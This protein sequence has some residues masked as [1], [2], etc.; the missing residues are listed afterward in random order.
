[1][2]LDTTHNAFH[3]SYIA[4]N[5]FRKA[6]AAAAGGSYPPHDPSLRDANGKPLR[7]DMWYFDND[8]TSREKNPGLAIFLSHSDCD[9]FLTPSECQIIA[10][11]IEALLP[12]IDEQDIYTSD[13]KISRG[14]TS[15][16]ARK[17]I[18]GCRL[19]ARKQE[20]LYFM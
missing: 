12:I 4:F 20:N 18:N 8:I 11:E 6:V 13:P 16:T 9:G 15:N 2:G 14:W 3:G 7:D 5:C 19:A 1:M 17:W 10:D